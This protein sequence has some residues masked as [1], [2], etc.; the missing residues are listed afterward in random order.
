MWRVSLTS[1]ALKPNIVHT[2][3]SLI[4]RSDTTYYI[5][6][7]VYVCS[8]HVIGFCSTNAERLNN[9]TLMTE[10]IHLAEVFTG[11]VISE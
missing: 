3:V 9:Q 8:R 7:Y 1:K 6:N 2:A 11:S 10:V 4:Q 5:I